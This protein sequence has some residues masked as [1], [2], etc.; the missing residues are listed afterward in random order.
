[1]SVGL[2]LNLMNELNKS[3]LCEPLANNLVMNL[4]KFNILFN[5]LY[6][7]KKKTLNCKKRSFFHQTFNVMLMF[8]LLLMLCLYNTNDVTSKCYYTSVISFSLHGF[9]TLLHH[10]LCDVVGYQQVIQKYYT[11]NQSL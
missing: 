2:I 10:V 8:C 4:H 6:S 9:I 5:T 11:R 1:M 3:I 7:Q